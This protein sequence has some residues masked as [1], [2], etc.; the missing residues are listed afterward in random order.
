MGATIISSASS[1]LVKLNP[2]CHMKPNFAFWHIQS[3]V[4]MPVGGV[5]P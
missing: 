3:S 1:N 5:S 2:I 4:K